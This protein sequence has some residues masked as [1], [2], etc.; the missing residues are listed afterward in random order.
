MNYTPDISEYASFSRFQW[1]W[2]YDEIIKSKQLCRWLGPANG[3]G[4]EF[5][6]YILNNAG[7]F[8]TQSSVIP[9]D[10]HELT[11]DHITKQCKNFME[12]VEYKIKNAK[13]PLFDSTEPDIIYYSA[14]GDTNDVDDNVLPYGGEIQYHK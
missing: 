4:K 12:R 5:F 8:I 7:G 1:L 3:F 2:F 14:F 9:I 11:T 6:S 10:D 13:Q